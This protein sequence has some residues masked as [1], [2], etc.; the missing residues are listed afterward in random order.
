LIALPLLLLTL[1]GVVYFLSTASGPPPTEEELLLRAQLAW[2]GEDH[3]DPWQCRECHA[4]EVAAWE[5]SHH[6]QANDILN[7]VDRERLLRAHHDPLAAARLLKYKKQ[8]GR[9]VLH[10][11]ASEDPFPV[12]GSIGLE[13]LVQYLLFAPDGRLQ[14][15]DVSWDV[16]KEEWFSMYED[17]PGPIRKAGEW[18]HW[19]G[20]G[21]NWDANCAYC[22]MTEYKKG[23]DPVSDRYDRKWA[24]MGITCA[25]CHPGVKT[26]LSQIRNGNP[27]YSETLDPV[28]IMESCAICHSRRDELTPHQFQAGDDFEDHFSLTLADAAGVYHPDGQVIMENYVYGSLTMS[29]MGHAGVTCLDCHDPHSHQ[30][31][32]PLEN[33][34]LCQRCH[35]SGLD[36]APVIEP[37]SHSH[38]AADSM[39]NRCVEC[40]MPH[41]FFMARDARR[42]H[43]FSIPDPS[44]TLEF[45][46]PN[47]CADCHGDMTTEQLHEQTVAWYGEDFNTDRRE[48]ARLVSALQSGTS[49]MGARLRS[50][51]AKEENRYWR[52]TMVA[53]FRNVEPEA[54]TWEALQASLKDPE[55]LV[56]AAAT[57]VVGIGGLSPEQQESLYNDPSR[58]VRIAAQMGGLESGSV[59]EAHHEELEA[60]IQHTADS[61]LGA[62]RLAR[63]HQMKADTPAAMRAIE[64]AVRFE[65]QNAETLRLAG[66]ESFRI[67][68]LDKAWELLER[69]RR[70]EP[71]NSVVLFNMGLL[72]TETGDLSRAFRYL[73][74]ATK[75]EPANAS[76]WYNLIVLYWQQ[77]DF[78]N[79]RRVMQEA[80]TA[81]PEDQ[82]LRELNRQLRMR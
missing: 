32:L 25:Q 16:E 33:N 63:F 53:L 71:R 37:V 6:H 82:R 49:G 75:V 68:N 81:L 35:A 61:P 43:S 26:H 29:T 79:A 45:G 54:E 22:H 21:M 27:S 13:P 7:D 23:Y 46:I 36:D 59:P 14:T 31:I 52:A 11:P 24:H 70:A 44:L 57:R 47:A 28:Q 10:D 3:A 42:D 69:A 9:M 12:M 50:A 65:P 38:H 80:L 73:G 30:L 5:G 60:Y 15:H 39:G 8:G 41:S 66:I 34:A 74:E 76:A 19:T 62:L 77:E 1:A 48:K 78:E 40:H 17:E 67:G 20:Q 4:A 55:P 72:A 2:E 64:L 58:V 18:G 51:V 56:R